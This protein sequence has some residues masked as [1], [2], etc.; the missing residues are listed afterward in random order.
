M[1]IPHYASHYLRLGDFVV[2][3]PLLFL[4]D[5]KLLTLSLFTEE[6]EST[7]FIDGVIRLRHSDFPENVELADE[8]CV[9][10]DL[11]TL[12]VFLSQIEYNDIE[13]LFP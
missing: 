4:R 6:I 8:D 13:V 5:G 1:R 2:P 11:S 3:Y 9:R 10:I 12:Q 7:I